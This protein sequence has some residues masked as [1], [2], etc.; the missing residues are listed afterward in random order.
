M[1]VEWVTITGKLTEDGEIIVDLPEGWI[2]GDCWIEITLKE[3][4][5]PPP[6]QESDEPTPFDKK[7]D[8]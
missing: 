7:D 4:Y 5:L 1:A 3:G 6:K 8:D 2:P